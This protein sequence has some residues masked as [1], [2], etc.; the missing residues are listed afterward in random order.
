MRTIDSSFNKIWRA[1]SNHSVLRTLLVYWAILTLGPL[2]L[3]T[4]FIVT[5]YLSSLPLISHVVIEHSNWLIYWLPLTFETIT[6]ALM[7]YVIPNRKV[8][9][10]HALLAGLVTALLVEVAKTLFAMFV[11][12][13]S[14]YQ[15]IFGALASIPLFLIW[16]YVCWS[17]LLVGAELCHALEAFNFKDEKPL[18]QPLIELIRVLAMLSDSQQAGKAVTEQTLK[19]T[20]DWK[21]SSDGGELLSK[22]IGAGLVSRDLS[23]SYC[24]IPLSEQLTF[25]K[26]FEILEY[27]LPSQADIEVSHLSESVK[28]QLLYV[29]EQFESLMTTRLIGEEPI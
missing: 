10:T 12:S 28:S 21:E 9:Y 4:S 11:T 27:R 7:L 24:L 20:L 23:L 13:F 26:L 16:V 22:L 5:S 8:R 29:V 6:F 14:T 17:I 3:G 15:V 1:K 19:Q 2:L 18:Q 25:S